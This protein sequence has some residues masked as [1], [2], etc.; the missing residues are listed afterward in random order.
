MLAIVNYV[1][2]YLLM[3]EILCAKNADERKW[4]E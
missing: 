4:D 3:T 2:K 1:S